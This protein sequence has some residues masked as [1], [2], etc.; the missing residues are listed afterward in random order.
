MNW[1]RRVGIWLRA[2]FGNEHWRGELVG[3]VP[4][5]P[6][7][8]T[9]YLL[10][11]EGDRPWAAAL[12]CPCGCR[13]LIQLS[14]ITDDNPSWRVHISS[15]GLATL[16]PSVWRV[17]GCRSHFFVRRGRIM[18]TKNGRPRHGRPALGRPSSR[19]QI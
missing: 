2:L 18:W 13:E 16:H 15:D 8:Q 12:L 7:P 17:R 19:R 6:A 10:G 9:V 3:E 5:Q 11:D 4:D 14:L 1:L